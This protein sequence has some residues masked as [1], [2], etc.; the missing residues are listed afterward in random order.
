MRSSSDRND[1]HAWR[2]AVAGDSLRKLIQG[3]EFCIH[4]GVVCEHAAVY[5]GVVAFWLVRTFCWKHGRRKISWCRGRRSDK[6][7]HQIV[8]CCAIAAAEKE[9]P[10]VFEFVGRDRYG[11]Q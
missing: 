5:Q 11:L 7:A 1:Q 3:K 2:S 10:A 4:F 8:S 6:I 9:W